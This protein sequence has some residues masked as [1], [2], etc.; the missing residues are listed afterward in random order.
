MASQSLVATR[1]PVPTRPL[2]RPN[3]RLT[4]LAEITARLARPLLPPRGD[5]FLS[6]AATADEVLRLSWWRRDLTACAELS[7]PS[8]GFC[9]E[10]S[11]EG[12]LQRAGAELLDY[13]SGRW[14]D[15]ATPD[16]I[17]VITDG[18]GVAF[19]PKHPS[20]LVDNWLFRHAAGECGIVT[21]L[22]LA[23]SG[24]CSLLHHPVAS[25][26]IH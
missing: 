1:A 21:I 15:N 13:L 24:P 6:I 12:Q 20:P 16:G 22:P 7:A 11:A 3:R 26:C 4:T 8:A 9:D 10:V 17:G 2:A 5:L 19:S 18:F 23:V 25:A 14:P